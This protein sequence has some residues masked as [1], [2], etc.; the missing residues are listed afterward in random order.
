ML[1]A[2]S[3]ANSEALTRIR[4]VLS[5]VDRLESPGMGPLSVALRAL[6]GLVRQGSS[7]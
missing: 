5:N 2:W 4:Q 1:T 3:E 7:S 6:R